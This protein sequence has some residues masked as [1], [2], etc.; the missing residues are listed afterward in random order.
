MTAKAAAAAMLPVRI[1]RRKVAGAFLLLL[2]VT[3]CWRGA[4]FI[5]ETGAAVSYPYGIDYGEGIVWQQMRDMFAGTAYGSIQEF[6][7]IVYHYPPLFHLASGLTA[8]FFGTDELAAGRL[9]SM[10]STLVVATLAG[11]LAGRLCGYAS[12]RVRLV[13]SA[14]AGL[15]MLT[16][17]PVLS[18]A[19]LMRVDMIALALSFGGTWL[20]IMALQRPRLIHPA[21]VLLVAALFA[22]QTMIAA[23]A[24]LFLV[25]LLFRPRLARAGLATAL[26]AGMA[27]LVLLA[28]LT[29]GGFLRHVFLYNVNRLELTRL[30]LLVEIVKAHGLYAVVAGY[31]VVLAARPCLAAWR[32]SA[33]FNCFRE[34]FSADP[35]L[36]GRI[37]FLAWFCCATMML[38]LVAKIGSTFNYMLEWM[39]IGSV[40]VGLALSRVVAYSVGA[41]PRQISMPVLLLPALLAAQALLIPERPYPSRNGAQ[42]PA[43]LAALVARIRS[44]DAPVISDEMVLLLRAGQPVLWESSIFAELGSKG[45]YDE[46]P[47]VDLILRRHFAFF[48]TEAERGDPLFH[49][50]YNP[51]IADAIDESY[52]RKEKILGLTLHLPP[53]E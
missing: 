19:P 52:P 42:A 2:G 48:V 50:R 8:M 47:M 34:R 38:L 22:K 44:A 49:Q 16:L 31:G 28:W 26:A 10:V 36:A 37:V 11:L 46:A 35:L 5:R 3:L 23:P 17:W 4:V 1:P 20:A 13:C 40:F 53:A 43:E 32:D 7:S 33:D 51:A 18:W 27:T 15:T 9:V 6:P 29:E 14:A 41:G 21:A 12:Y 39:A 24:G 25:L 30:L 45:K